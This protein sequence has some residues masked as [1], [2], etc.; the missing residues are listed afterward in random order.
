MKVL[1]DFGKGLDTL[2]AELQSV[3]S[4]IYLVIVLLALACMVSYALVIPG[5]RIPADSKE[6]WRQNCIRVLLVIYMVCIFAITVF[7]RDT[8]EIYRMQLVPLNGLRD[9]DHINRELIRDGANLLLFLPLGFLF[10]WQHK[11]RGLLPGSFGISVGFSLSV[12]LIQ[13]GRAHV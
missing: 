10:A 6:T 12:E 13:I 8:S 5:I 2:S 1:S 11:R 4:F 3:P 9:F 7:S